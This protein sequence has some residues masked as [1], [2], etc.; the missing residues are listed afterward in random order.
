MMDNNSKFIDGKWVLD[1]E[2]YK[3]SYY[4]DNFEKSIDMKDLC[5]Q[6]L[7]GMQW[8]LSYYTRGVPDWKWC[9]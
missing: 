2:K 3:E 7:K 9:F 1:I 6:Y 8:V 4:R 5:H